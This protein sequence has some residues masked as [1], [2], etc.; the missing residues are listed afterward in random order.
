M[1]YRRSG[2]QSSIIA[3][4]YTVFRKRAPH[5]AKVVAY[6]SK[7]FNKAMRTTID[8]SLMRQAMRSR[9][10]RTKCAVVEEALRLLI[11]TRGQSSIRRLR[12]NVNWAADLAGSGS[13]DA[14]K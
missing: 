11:R 9:G 12:G 13:I 14:A 4:S 1:R 8:D 2:A 5:F 10:A 6:H 3:N 7:R